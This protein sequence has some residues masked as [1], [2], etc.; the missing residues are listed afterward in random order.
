MK[1]DNAREAQKGHADSAVTRRG[2]PER[3]YQAQRAGVFMR[4]VSYERLS[5]FDAERW[6]ARWEREGEATG[7]ERG[8]AG[9][10]DEGWQWI[11][12]QREGSGTGP[13][14]E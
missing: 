10:W 9:Y 12:G 5:R 6:I 4:L 3:I 13:G 8:S 14:P 2:D 1:A 7:R 11:S